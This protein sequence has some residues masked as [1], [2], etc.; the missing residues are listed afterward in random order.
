MDC[1]MPGFP[2]HHKLPELTQTHVHWVDDVIWSHHFMVNRWRINGNSDRLYFLGHKSHWLNGHE[3]EQAPR[4]GD[5]QGSMAFCSPWGSIES[6]MIEPL[7]WLTET[8]PLLSRRENLGDVIL[9][10][11]GR[12]SEWTPGVG[13]GQGGLACCYSWGPKELDMSERLKWTEYWDFC[14]I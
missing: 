10:L 12:E 11:N 4:V 8:V 9:R 13:D 5:G 14:L 1:R 2:A 6:D 7:N 3:F